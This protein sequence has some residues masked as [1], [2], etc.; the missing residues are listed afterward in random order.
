MTASDCFF[1][2]D[3]IDF[4]SAL[5]GKFREITATCIK[6]LYLR[7]N[8]PE[9]DYSYNLNRQDVLDIFVQS[10]RENPVIIESGKQDQQYDLEQDHSQQPKVESATNYAKLARDTYQRL[11]KTGWIEDYM[12]PGMMETAIR[13]TAQ[14]R[15]FAMVFAQHHT[16]II[17]NSQHTRSTLSHLQTFMLR[18]KNNHISIGD[19]MIATKLAYEIISDFNELIEELVEKRRELMASVSEEIQQAKKAGES[20][21]DFM[22]KRFMPDIRFRFSADSVER[23]RNEILEIV[24]EIRSL[25]NT[26]KIRIEKEIQVAYPTLCKPERPIVLFWALDQIEHHVNTACDVKLPE[27]RSETENFVRRAQAL[28][29]HI[30]S[31][32]FSNTDVE[33]VFNIV[34]RLAELNSEDIEQVLSAPQSRFGLMNISLVNPGKILPPHSTRKEVVDTNFTD[35][36]EMSLEARRE[37][38]IRHQLER[39]FAVESDK[40]KDY[41]IK[42]LAGGYKIKASQ[43]PITDAASFLAALHAPQLASVSGGEKAFF[44]IHPSPVS[45]VNEYYTGDGFELEYL[46]PD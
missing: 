4:F 42:Q 22:Q 15:Q 46:P 11:K 26:V 14:G 13:F 19:L 6:N 41:V 18:L 43:L 5:A 39:A 25:D 7:L 20:F 17:T 9:A 16:E 40:I 34:G 2:D 37:A 10:I 35:A 8:G 30:A 29:T 3:R 27:L 24:N 31:L 44:R 12:D 36:L 45:I 33:S 23:Y 32:S 28:I 1:V 21:F 38:F